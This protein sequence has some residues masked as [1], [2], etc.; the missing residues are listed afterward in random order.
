MAANVETM[1]YVRET[2]WHGLGTRVEEALCSADAL[3]I[4]GLDWNVVQRPSYVGLEDGSFVLDTESFYNVRDTDNA[5]L[6]KVGKQYTIVQNIDA[7]AFS[8]ALLGE[9]VKYETAGS[10]NG[11][12]RVWIL[13]RMPETYK[14]LGDEYVAYLVLTNTHDGTGSIRIALTP[15]RV[16]CQNTLNA[17]LS[18]AKRSWS[19][20]HKRSVNNKIDEARHTLGLADAYM[21]A[22][23]KEMEKLA[24]V[25]IS[26]IQ[27]EKLVLPGLFKV[28]DSIMTPRQIET[29][30]TQRAELRYRYQK[31]P[32]LQG[33]GF[34]GAR[35]I[36]AVA[37]YVDHTTPAKATKNWKENRF[38]S[39]IHKNDL[40]DQARDLV[41]D[42]A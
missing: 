10:L 25:K 40:L 32:D 8:D 13:A 21:K 37:D 26:P 29:K 17:A 7:F 16:V 1:F 39:Q 30:L 15:I 35:L 28:D 23:N 33:V 22:L 42:I 11:G 5:I 20:V 12:K 36:Q 41:L 9:G 34:N 27:F 6:G 14:I 31:A 2:P 38:A 24:M 19:A 18:G 3:R 4:S